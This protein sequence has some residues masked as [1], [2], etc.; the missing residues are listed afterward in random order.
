MSTVFRIINPITSKFKLPTSNMNYRAI[1]Y[2]YKMIT[3][4][5]SCIMDFTKFNN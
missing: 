3:N 2:I 1:L 5:K 4:F